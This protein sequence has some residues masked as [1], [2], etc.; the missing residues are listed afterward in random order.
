MINLAL[1]FLFK[2]AINKGPFPEK[3]QRDPTL[4]PQRFADILHLKIEVKELSGDLSYNQIKQKI[5]L[6]FHKDTRYW[7]QF[8]FAEVYFNRLNKKIIVI[9][10][11]T[12]LV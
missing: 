2:Q 9:L 7:F 1:H 5:R 12:H 6:I 8:H 11:Y 10:Y 3:Y 4:S